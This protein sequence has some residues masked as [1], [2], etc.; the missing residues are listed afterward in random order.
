MNPQDRYNEMMKGFYIKMTEYKNNIN[1]NNICNKLNST[2]SEL[3]EKRE[4]YYHQ[5]SSDLSFQNRYRGEI[6]SV[7]RHME[8]DFNK[9]IEYE[10]ILTKS[11]DLIIEQNNILLILNIR[12]IIIYIIKIFLKALSYIVYILYN[13]L[14]IYNIWFIKI[15]LKVLS[16][17]V[18][19]LYNKV[20]HIKLEKEEEIKELNKCPICF[21]NE[22][23]MCLNP[24]GHCYCEICIN[25]SNECFICRTNII[26]KIKLFF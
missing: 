5:L 16:Y 15:F 14:L 7:N 17:V 24:C 11:L 26:N 21:E 6:L 20:I 2:I 23:N 13:I 4:I 25:N 22:I 10:A 9:S 12:F 19:I 3:N 8:D 18:S 1:K